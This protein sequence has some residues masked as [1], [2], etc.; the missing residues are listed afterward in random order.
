M[1]AASKPST[2]LIRNRLATGSGSSSCGSRSCT[3]S[4]CCIP[5]SS[6]SSKGCSGTLGSTSSSSTSSGSCGH[7]GISSNRSSLGRMFGIGSNM[8]GN[9]RGISSKS[10]CGSAGISTSSTSHSRGSSSSSSA[11]NS[12]S[13]TARLSGPCIIITGTDSGR[14]GSCS[15]RSLDATAIGYGRC[16]SLGAS[17]SVRPTFL[18]GRCKS[19]GARCRFHGTAGSSVCSCSSAGH[20]G[21]STRP[22]NCCR[23]S[24]RSRHSIGPLP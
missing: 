14:N 24:C 9:S 6:G 18:G 3:C 10:R 17:A 20:T 19:R 5:S 12:S 13:T 23:Y 21:C 11:T 16:R 4:R 1:L 15:C 8:A 22:C 2:T 7:C